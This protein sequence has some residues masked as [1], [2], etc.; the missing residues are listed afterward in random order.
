MSSSIFDTMG[1]PTIT[2]NATDITS[3]TL[4]FPSSSDNSDLYSGITSNWTSDLSVQGNAKIDGDLMIGNRSL[5]EALDKIE[6]RLAILQPNRELE[7]KWEELQSL[8]EQYR[9][10]EAEILEKE[11]LWNI[12][13]K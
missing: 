10:L 13:S 11:K 4:V 5:L 6:A 8:G 9:K 1:S 3:D 7:S 2:I 12:V